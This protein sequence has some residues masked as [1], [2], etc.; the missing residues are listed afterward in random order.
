MGKWTQEEI[1]F[2]KKNYKDHYNEWIAE[3]LNRTK[4]SVYS[5]AHS[6]NLKH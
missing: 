5:K 3:K 1:D 6:L 4:E 2:L